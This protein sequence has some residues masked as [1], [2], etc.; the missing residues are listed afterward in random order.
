MFILLDNPTM[1][2][3]K[4]FLFLHETIVYWAQENLN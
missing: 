4:K 1:S 2:L 3:T